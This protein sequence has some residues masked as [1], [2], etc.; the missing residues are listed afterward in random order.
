MGGDLTVCTM[1]GDLTVCT[2]GGDEAG[3]CTLSSRN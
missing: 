1:G 3:T 2:M